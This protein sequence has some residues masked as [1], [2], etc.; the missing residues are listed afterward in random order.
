LSFLTFR[1]KPAG[2]HQLARIDLGQEECAEYAIFPFGSHQLK[3]YV[4]IR[5]VVRLR[6]ESII[7]LFCG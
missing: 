6:V 7:C 4:I 3:P 1:L 2:F 5:Q